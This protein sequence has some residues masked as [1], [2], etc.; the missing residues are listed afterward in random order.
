MKEQNKII[1]SFDYEIY[2]DGSNNYESLLSNTE[3][4]LITAKKTQSKL[5]FF[6]DI[7]YLIQLKKHQH[8]EIYNRIESQ[9]NDMI[10]D[11]HEVQFHFHPHWIHARFDEVDKKWIF[12]SSEYSFSDIIEKY[13]LEYAKQ[14]FN[15]AYQFLNQQFKLKSNAFRAGG[16]SID[17]SQN[18]LIELLKFNKIQYDSSVMPGLKLKGKYID[19]NHKKAPLSA[20]WTVENSFL[21]ASQNG[22]LI[23]V[24]LMSINP[25]KINKIKRIWTSVQYRW[26]TFVNRKNYYTKAEPRQI[27]DLKITESDYP[28]NITFDK[29][30]TR[31]LI[32]LKF[33]TKEFLKE[34]KQLMCILSHPKSFI[35]PSFDVFEN[36]LKWI[37]NHSSEYK[38]VGFND[39][40]L[41]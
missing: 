3:K 22:H 18:E 30:R 31:D 13:G 37:N 17:Q 38:I 8:S 26:V 34:D 7:M 4:I 5:V 23:E 32:L 21:N 39:L 33:F 20:Y 11:G 36:Y 16:L 41:I 6:V 10:Q 2:F 40:K 25:D 1:I 29:S 19:I 14:Q 9:I 12:D 35:H 28:R 15:D 27:I 24:P